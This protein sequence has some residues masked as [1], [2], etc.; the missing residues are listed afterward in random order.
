MVQM[1]REVGANLIIT[2]SPATAS[3]LSF[4]LPH[5]PSIYVDEKQDVITQFD[6]WPQ[7]TDAASANDSALFITRSEDNVPPADLARNFASVW[8]RSP[9]CRCRNSTNHGTSGAASA[10]PAPRSRPARPRR[11]RCTNRIRFRNNP[12]PDAATL[13]AFFEFLR[14]GSISTDSQYKGQ[15]NACAEW[16]RDRLKTAGFDAQLLPTAGHPVV[17][18]RGPHKAGRPTVLIYGHYD[19]QPVDPIDLWSHA[20]FEPQVESGLITARGAS[21]N[22]GQIFFRTSKG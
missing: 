16:L 13:D 15:V 12:M 9:T 2:D 8:L 19:V 21:D 6:F 18:A 7:Y 3:E 10:S 14:F 17:L 20:P 1:Q 22:K 4:Y 11:G 5:H